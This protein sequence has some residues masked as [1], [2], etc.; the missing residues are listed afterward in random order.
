MHFVIRKSGY[1]KG[2]HLF[3]GYALFTSLQK[4]EK[5]F[6]TLSKSCVDAGS[7]KIDC[8]LCYSK[9]CRGNQLFSSILEWPKGVKAWK[10]IAAFW[11]NNFWN[12][13]NVRPSSRSVLFSFQTPLHLFCQRIHFDIK[14][15]TILPY[16]LH[17]HFCVYWMAD[18]SDFNK[19]KEYYAVISVGG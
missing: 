6:Y 14:K 10:S 3:E 9:G 15:T 11:T 1:L 12:Y 2:T 4:R 18:I 16:F 5:S 7:N 17:T 8:M 13:W 19:T